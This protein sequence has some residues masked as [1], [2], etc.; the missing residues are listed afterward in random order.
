MS[1]N[2]IRCSY[3]DPELNRLLAAS[4][5]TSASTSGSC[6]RHYNQVGE[7]FLR[8]GGVLDVPP[9][10]IHHDVHRDVPEGGYRERLRE[11]L[12]QLLALAP[13]LF[14]ELTHLFE[15]ADTLRPAFF[16]L[17][18]IETSRYLYLLRLDLMY[19]PQVH[20]ASTSEGNDFSPAYS[21]DR[22]HLEA[23]AVPLE[24]VEAEEGRIRELRIDQMI[25]NT[26]VDEIGRGYAVQGIWIDNDLTRFFSKLFLPPGARLHPFY[27]FICKYKSVCAALIDFAPEIREARLSLLHRALGLLRPAMSEIEASMKGGQ[28]SDGNPVFRRLKARVPESWYESWTGLRLEAYLDDQN[29]KEYRV[30]LPPA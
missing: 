7:F 14:A 20:R 12:E 27:P 15:P 2:A 22:L 9:L 4:G 23:L 1:A 24:A 26:F 6:T 5:S 18:R 17:Y 30:E 16:K 28:F 21:T 8:L 19:R 25:S 10:A 29:M 11:V 13:E 3:S